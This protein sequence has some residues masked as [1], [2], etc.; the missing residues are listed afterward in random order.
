M[1]A[2]WFNSLPYENVNTW[3]ELMGAYFSKFFPLSIASEQRLEITNSKHGG[4]ENM[5]TA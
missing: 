3:E 2:A 5:F 1:A 4:D